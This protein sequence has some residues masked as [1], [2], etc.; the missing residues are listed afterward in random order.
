MI[1]KRPREV[2]VNNDSR[3]VKVTWVLVSASL[4]QRNYLV[5]RGRGLSEVVRLRL[6]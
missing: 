6:P 2:A 3:S 1:N 5:L 4:N